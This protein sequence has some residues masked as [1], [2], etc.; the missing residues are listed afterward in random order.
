[1]KKSK[2]IFVLVGLCSAM[3][4]QAQMAAWQPGSTSSNVIYNPESGLPSSTTPQWS[5]FYKSPEKSSVKVQNGKLNIKSVDNS[6]YGYLLKGTDFVPQD[7]FSFDIHGEQL[8]DTAAFGLDLRFNGGKQIKLNIKN[9]EVIDVNRN[10]TVAATSVSAM[11]KYRIVVDGNDAALYKN[12]DLVAPLSIQPTDTIT[13]GGFERISSD[14]AGILWGH[15]GY[16]GV[17]V[18]STNKHS[19]SKS[20]K[21]ENGWNGRFMGVIKVQPNSTYT[22]KYWASLEIVSAW[23]QKQM[24][25]GVWVDGIQ[26]G[27]LPV[28]EGWKE[29]TCTFT[30]SATTNDISLYYHNGWTS[31][32]NFTIYFDDIRLTRTAGDP[33]VQFGNL[34][35]SNTSDINL[36]KISFLNGSAYKPVLGT[37]LTTLIN[38]ATTKNNAAQVGSANGE[39][40]QYAKDLFTARINEVSVVASNYIT[41]PD[42]VDLAYARLQQ[43]IDLFDRSMI[44]NASVV[45]Q[46]IQAITA[47]ANLKTHKTAQ[48]NVTGKLSDNSNADLSIANIVYTSLTPSYLSVDASGLAEALQPGSGKI[49]VVVQLNTVTLKDTA[50][51]N[52]IEYNLASID[53]SAYSPT[54]LA[55]E[56][57]G[58][59]LTVKM[60][61]NTIPD[62]KDLAIA[63]TSLSPE[64]VQVNANGT[65]LGK[66]SGVAEVEVAATVFGKTLKDTVTVTVIDL[67]SIVLTPLQTTL[68]PNTK[69]T[70][71]FTVK[72]TDGSYAVI[73]GHDA[74]IWSN[75]RN[76]VK[77]DDKGNLKADSIGTAVVELIVKKGTITKKVS[78]TITVS[79]SLN[80][81]DG[82]GADRVVCIAYPSAFV[83]MLTVSAPKAMKQLTLVDLA[84]KTVYKASV[85][86]ETS[87]I[88]SLAM[89]NRGVYLLNISFEDGGSS[90]LRVLKK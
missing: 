73:D 48:I 88:L 37:D 20:M 59:K 32:G 36:G 38:T 2:N 6:I 27:N 7:K 76:A 85:N 74:V 75:N 26:V 33:Y 18:V 49:E 4:L 89:L 16:T 65:I 19:G 56:A 9:G 81:I 30:T 57:A 24:N 63:Y 15:D 80:S 54:I 70:Y 83:D 31:D 58:S 72:Y 40:P 29:Y 12:F 44:T 43:S 78:A 64:K 67:E 13:D 47:D 79:A 71:V 39:Y 68:T 23:G 51:F 60:S 62:S 50:D 42:S 11:N 69:S 55:G 46:S 86:G 22:L 21:W 3:G 45:L 87:K 90:A 53:A 66:A 61:D 34:Y 8:T 41:D 28:T 52:L 14:E 35:S 1:M 84:G 77:I 5:D 25:G 82:N 10:T 17:S